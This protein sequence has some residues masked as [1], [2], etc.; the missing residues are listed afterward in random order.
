VVPPPRT[1]EAKND[2]GP[3][4]LGAE[5]IGGQEPDPAK[6]PINPQVAWDWA[7]P[8]G[9]DQG[10]SIGRHT[11]VVRSWCRSLRP[12]GGSGWLHQPC[13]W[14]VFSLFAT[15][16]CIGLTSSFT[17]P[18]RRSLRIFFPHPPIH[19]LPSL[20]S[21]HAFRDLLLIARRAPGRFLQISS[22]EPNNAVTTPRWRHQ[23]RHCR[24]R[25]VHRRS[26]AAPRPRGS[27]CR[28]HTHLSQVASLS[29]GK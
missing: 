13:Q 19:H 7:R 29:G 27:Q 10:R 4:T 25:P 5:H 17:C 9:D 16:G 23:R 12:L 20:A 26:T 1:R 3:S 15:V 21:R 8:L 2:W 24:S 11:R 18:S 14:A 6:V 28:Q 22:R